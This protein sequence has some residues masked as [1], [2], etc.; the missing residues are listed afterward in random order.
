MRQAQHSS[1]LLT[2]KD[3]RCGHLSDDNVLPI[4]NLYEAEP[5]DEKI[6]PHFYER[7]SI[8]KTFPILEAVAA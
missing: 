4:I 7:E 8:R 3:R 6:L 2:S 1:V 5:H